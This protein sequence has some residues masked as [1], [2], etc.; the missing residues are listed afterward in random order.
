MPDELKRAAACFARGAF[1]EAEHL[2]REALKGVPLDPAAHVLLGRTFQAKGQVDAAQAAFLSAVEAAPALVDAW[3]HWAKFLQTQGYLQKAESCLRMA[4]THAPNAFAIHN[5]LALILLA[6]GN[7]EG[8]E[9]HL[10]RALEIL[11]RS[12]MALCNLGIVRLHQGKVDEAIAAYRQA[13]AINPLI[14]EAHNNLGDVLKSRDA[15]AAA[16]SFETALTLRPD[17]PEAL[18]NL[19]VV[20]FFN[21]R[22]QDALD[23]F[24]RALAAHPGFHRAMAHKTTTLFMLG[25]LGEAWSA[26]RQRF[27]VA[28][29][30]TPPHGRFSV[31]VWNGEPLAG[32]ALLIWTELGLGEEVLQAGMFPDAA[33]IASRLTVECSPRLM[34]LFARSFPGVSFIPRLNAARASTAPVVADYQIAGGDLGAA[35]RND[36]DAFPRHTGYLTADTRQVEALRRKYR[37]PESLVVG[38]SW[39]SR[40]SPL[41]A[42]KTMALSEFAPILRQPGI[43]FVNLQYGYEP[44]DI[45]AM[46]AALGVEIICDDAVDLSGDMDA[47]AA[48]IAAMDLVISVSNTAVHIAGALNVPVWNIV[49]GHNASGMWHWFYESEQSPWYPSMRIYRRTQSGNSDLMGRIAADL[50]DFRIRHLKDA[51]G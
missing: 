18:D 25:R 39:A 31:P 27:T 49:P 7:P 12:E 29:I 36:F 8:A 9:G 5:D 26:Y 48:Q 43:V 13:I 4:L 35:F 40:K 47:V 14:P 11:P 30:K 20:H 51:E 38:L 17:F 46:R 10:E 34:T 33:R 50:Q 6:L 41:D 2:C 22:L 24:D 32:K 21:G 16:E 19:G 42:V 1:D 3:L 23:K 45:A 37:K 28:G 15:K 44:D